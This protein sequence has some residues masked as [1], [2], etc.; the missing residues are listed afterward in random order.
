M[1]RTA[2]YL[3]HTKMPACLRSAALDEPWVQA[4]VSY[5]VSVQQ[6]GEEALQAQAVT[7]VRAGAELPLKHTR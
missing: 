7:S 2:E 5:V 6:P 1:E 3:S 4:D